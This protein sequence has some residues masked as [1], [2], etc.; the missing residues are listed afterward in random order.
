MFSAIDTYVGL[1]GAE[2]YPT[3]IRKYEPKTI[4]IYLQDGSNDLDIYAG[5]WW[6]AAQTMER[7]LTFAGYEVNHLWG[8]D[9]HNGKQGTSS[10]PDAMRWLWKGWPKPVAKGNSKNQFLNDLLIP[11]EDWQLVGEGYQFTE[12]TATNEKGEVFYQDIPTSKTYK[13]DHYCPTMNRTKSTV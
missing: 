8:E 3:L 6:M 7:A 13:V 11:S 4:R 5:D 1:R 10:F 12:G 2:R 9:G